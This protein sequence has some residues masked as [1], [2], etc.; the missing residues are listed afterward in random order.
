[1]PFDFFDMFGQLRI[2][3]FVL[4]RRKFLNQE[5]KDCSKAGVYCCVDLDPATV[6]QF[7]VILA[8]LLP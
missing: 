1:M 4:R 8:A 5:L 2:Y 7:D 3:D 6:I